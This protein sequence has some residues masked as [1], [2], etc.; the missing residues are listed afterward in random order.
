MKNI[1]NTKERGF[2]VKLPVRLHEVILKIAY[3]NKLYNLKMGLRDKNKKPESIAKLIEI[4]L[5][6][7][8]LK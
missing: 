1:K 4:A 3:E 7:Y 6:K 8:Y 5:E 2:V